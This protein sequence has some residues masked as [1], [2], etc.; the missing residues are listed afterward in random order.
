[1]KKNYSAAREPQFADPCFRIS[2]SN[3]FFFV[4]NLFLIFFFN[5]YIKFNQLA[6]QG[7]VGLEEVHGVALVRGDGHPGNVGSEVEEEGV[8]AAAE[9]HR[10]EDAQHGPVG[11]EIDKDPPECLDALK[12]ILGFFKNLLCK[13]SFGQRPRQCLN[14]SYSNRIYLR[15]I[16]L[17]LFI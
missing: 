4:I 16:C 8:Q 7:V 2:D 10:G 6:A 11:V 12:N 3:T 1:M 14:K 15:T 17:E 9:A 13:L 5:L